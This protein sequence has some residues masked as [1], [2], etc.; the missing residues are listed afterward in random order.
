MT[1][2]RLLHLP[3]FR[4]DRLP[5]RHFPILL[6]RGQY[7]VP[8]RRLPRFPLSRCRRF[9]ARRLPILPFLRLP[10][11]PCLRRDGGPAAPSRTGPAAP[12]PPRPRSPAA[13]VRRRPAREGHRP[14]V[15]LLE[16]HHHRRQGVEPHAENHQGANSGEQRLKETP[17]KKGFGCPGGGTRPPADG[18]RSWKP[19][20]GQNGAPNPPGHP[21][22]L[23]QP[24]APAAFV[25]GGLVSGGPVSVVCVQECRPRNGGADSGTPDRTGSTRPRLAARWGG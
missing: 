12:D 17:R 16:Q 2:R 6:L 10:V 22:I 25:S 13:T 18:P 14:Q 15:P 20:A 9:P 11:L 8:S 21:T 24:A 4:L 23:V 19:K 3:S 1:W 5:S 7:V